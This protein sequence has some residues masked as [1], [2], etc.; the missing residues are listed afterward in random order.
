[1]SDD[2]VSII[3]SEVALSVLVIFTL[4][5]WLIDSDMR[6]LCWFLAL[7]M[8]FMIF[9]VLLAFYLKRERDE[10]KKEEKQYQKD[11]LAYLESQE[12]DNEK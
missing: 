3:I 6:A 11:F 10:K 8:F 9:N 2:K 1:M 12:K 5:S 7:S 4:F